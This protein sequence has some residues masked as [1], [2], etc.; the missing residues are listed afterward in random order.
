MIPYYYQE[1]MI[2]S[3]FEEIKTK[4]SVLCQS[5][6]G[7]G[8]T[9]IMSEFIRRWLLINTEKKVLIS[10]HRDELVNQTSNTLAV[11]GILNEKITAKSKNLF[12]AQVYVGMTQ[13]IWIRKISLD[14]G[15]LI[16][17]EAHEQI[18][19][20]TFDLFDGAKRVGFTATPVI[21][22]RLT[23]YKCGY[24]TKIHDSRV[25]CCYSE[26]VEKWSVPVTMSE[27]YAGFIKGVPI[28]TLI[29]ENSL[30]DEV[31]FSYDYYSDLEAKGNDDFDENDIAEE[32]AKHDLDVLLEYKEKC[33]GK[34]TMIFTASTK[35]N[36]SLV[37]V[38]TEEGFNIKSYDSV[39]NETKER[40]DILKWYRNNQNGI[41]VST[42]TFTTGF[43]D[44]EV[45]A[46]IINRPTSSLSLWHQMVGRGGRTSNKIYKPFLILI[47]LGGNVKRLGQWSQNVDWENIFY[48]GVKPAKKQK[49][50]LIQCDKCAYNWIGTNSDEC[51]DCGYKNQ[52]QIT[53]PQTSSQ[54]PE[55]ERVD[56]TTT[57][58]SVIP[59][60]NF[61]K[62][63]EF[64]KRTTDNKNEFYKL[65]IDKYVD[66]WK[67]NRVDVSIYNKRVENG[68]LE[69]KIDVYLKRNYGYSRQMSLG[70][71][72]TYD[73]L[74]EKIKEKLKACFIAKP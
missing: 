42:G 12:N 48:N 35:Q 25:D 30:V 44:K 34:K 23:I 56:K 19:V 50:E 57:A 4:D 53:A 49:E 40:A 55:L 46:I 59:L 73:Y 36:L 54:S 68:D 38:F 43:D 47:D 37:N 6:T 5:A 14:I 63:S 72:R 15:L 33:L 58:I 41:L 11:F 27:T 61:S 66:L 64:V 21:N 74:R 31:V 1:D 18:H 52:P 22:K 7:S 17:D 13:T 65:L 16:I 2:A 32:S 70:V 29:Q 10:V 62:I 67:Y 8:K 51:P 24:C 3:I 9:V 28:K 71:P 26:K 39:N 69:K 60:P 45:E 20:K